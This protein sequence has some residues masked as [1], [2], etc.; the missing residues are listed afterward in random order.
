MSHCWGPV[1][2]QPIRTL[3]ENIQDHYS[4]IPLTALPRTFQ[5]AVILTQRLGI[6][7]LWIDSLC[8]QQDD[9]DDWGREAASMGQLYQQATL[10]IAAFGSKD[11]T[12]GLFICERSPKVALKLPYAG[13]GKTDGGT[14]NIMFNSTYMRVFGPH[15]NPLQE[16]AWALQESYLS[17]RLVLFRDFGID[18]RCISCQL[19]EY[20]CYED[21]GL[22]ELLDWFTLLCVYSAKKLT[23]P[24]DRLPALQ[25]IVNEEGKRRDDAFLSEGVWEKEITEHLL[26]YRSS[27]LAHGDS[28]LPSWSWAATEGSKDWICR[29]AYNYELQYD[30]SC[31]IIKRSRPAHLSVSGDLVQGRVRWAQ[32]KVCCTSRCKEYLEGKEGPRLYMAQTH[33][34]Q[35][36]DGIL[37]FATLDRNEE[38][39]SSTDHSTLEFCILSKIK[40]SEISEKPDIEFP[41]LYEPC[42][43]VSLP[44]PNIT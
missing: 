44:R 1:D 31:V 25:G 32:M 34:L 17:R 14:F 24:S 42:L 13:N 15:T 35:N 10:V 7:Y 38:P 3:A 5:E 4:G 21:L 43:D 29:P 28:A 30:H 36:D 19:D 9:D 39:S 12:G 11:P 23:R 8:I 22:Y 37:G 40:T 2:R 6:D 27:V 20:G 33:L 16:R 41:E 18:W 26:W